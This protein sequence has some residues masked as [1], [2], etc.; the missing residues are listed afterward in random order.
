MLSRLSLLSRLKPPYP[1]SLTIHINLHTNPK[2][3]SRSLI[4]IEIIITILTHISSVRET[5]NINLFSN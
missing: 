4:V 3:F 2:K 5:P 1:S